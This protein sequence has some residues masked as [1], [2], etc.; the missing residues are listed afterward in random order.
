[1][2]K[3]KLQNSL[4]YLTAF[5]I[6]IPNAVREVSFVFIFIYSIY[7]LK[8][9]NLKI[10]LVKFFTLTGVFFISLISLLYT[11]NLYTGIKEIEGLIPII[12]LSFAFLVFSETNFEPDFLK[13]WFFY[14]NISNIIFLSFFTIYYFYSN[15]TI[16]FNNIRAMLELLPLINIHPIYL[17]IVCVI[18][19]ISNYYYIKQIIPM[20]CFLI[21]NLLLLILT[22]CRVSILFVFLLIIYFG[23]ISQIKNSLKIFTIIFFLILFA[24]IFI[25]NSDLSNKLIEITDKNTYTSFNKNSATSV[26]VEIFRNSLDVAK[27]TNYING[28]GIGDVR[29]LLIN[30]YKLYHPNLNKFYNT[31]NQF[32]GVFLS[33]GII[34][35]ICL[36]SLFIILFHMAFKQR[37][38]PLF[39]VLLYFLIM[40]LF[41]N[42][43]DRKNGI[44]LFLFSVFFIFNRFQKRDQYKL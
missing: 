23:I 19:I 36:I 7:I 34:G 40:F 42:V 5:F 38:N 6:L 43:M 10:N 12:Y 31:H 15:K 25:I 30:N 44:L 14:F 22:G 35:V 26:R 41:E 33:T 9:N 24:T 3:E 29:Q 21:I 8:K 2:K 20:I 4:F 18:A 11:K 16:S 27:Q 28:N 1:M 39:I 13:K 17:S 37:N 32:L